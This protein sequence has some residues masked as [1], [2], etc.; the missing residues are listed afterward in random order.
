VIRS[1]VSLLALLTLGLRAYCAV[2]MGTLGNDILL[3]TAPN[4]IGPWSDPLTLHHAMPPSSNW[5]YGAAVHGELARDGGRV[6][7]ATYFRPGDGS[8]LFLVEITFE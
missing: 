3:R 1:I 6:E 7:Y 5:D 4:P 8:G 2:Y